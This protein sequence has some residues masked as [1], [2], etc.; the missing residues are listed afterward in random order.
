MS[1][2]GDNFKRRFELCKF[3]VYVMRRHS[4]D[5]V[6]VSVTIALCREDALANSVARHALRRALEQVEKGLLVRSHVDDLALEA[7]EIRCKLA[8]T[9][10]TVIFLAAH[11]RL[12]AASNKKVVTPTTTSHKAVN[13]RVFTASPCADGCT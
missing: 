10:A 13:I 3:L 8:A 11:S 9:G 7:D 5:V 6:T 1:F 4:H 12:S 2:G